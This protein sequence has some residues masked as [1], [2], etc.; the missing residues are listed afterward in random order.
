MKTKIL[1]I[2]ILIL[3]LGASS[4]FAQ[5]RGGRG[6]RIMRSADSPCW[7]NPRFGATGEQLKALEELHR[8]YIVSLKQYQSQYIVEHYELRSLLSSPT[9]D[10]KLVI[11]KQNQVSSIRK[12][13]DEISLQYLLKA[14][15]IFS[16]EQISLLPYNCGLGFTYGKETGQTRS[17]GQGMRWGRGR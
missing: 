11:D 1:I 15:Q 8:S 17:W 12:K 9:P 13:I 6:G 2:F 7:K 4:L 3:I 5:S 14:R 10:S 16:L